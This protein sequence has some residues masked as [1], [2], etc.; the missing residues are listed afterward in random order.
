MRNLIKVYVLSFQSSTTP[1]T[2]ICKCTLWEWT[3]H[4][5]RPAL[6]QY[7]LRVRKNT[8]PY[9]VSMEDPYSS[10]NHGK[11]EEDSCSQVRGGSGMSLLLALE[12]EGGV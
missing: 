7:N 10:R 5:D 9:T 2:L 1:T 8:F 12:Q 3:L 4:S 11:G 6:F